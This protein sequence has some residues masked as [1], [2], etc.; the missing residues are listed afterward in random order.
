MLL[1]HGMEGQGPEHSSGRLERFLNMAVNDNLQVC[2]VTTPAQIFHLLRRQ[3]LRAYR[4]PLI[5]MSPKL[6]LRLPAAS[7]SL[8]ELATGQFRTVLPD[9]GA[10][11]AKVDRILLCSGKVYYDLA[12]ARAEHKLENVAIIRVEQLYPLRRD[13][14][15]EELSIYREGS[16]VIWVQEEHRNMGAWH[17]MSRNLPPLL[18]SAFRWSGISRPFSASPA[19]GSNSRHKLEH[20]K[21]M[22][23]ALGLKPGT[24]VEKVR[25]ELAKL[26]VK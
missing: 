5:V 25:E 22:E 24:R 1:P 8:T 11:P 14:I 20:A 3:V 13:E 2:N 6:L 9:E 12:A 16:R 18:L 26:G 21:L 4:K 15:L 17:F 19:T 7:S 10:D 23:E